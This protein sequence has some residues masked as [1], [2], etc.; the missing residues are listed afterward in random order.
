MKEHSLTW[1]SFIILFLAMFALSVAWDMWNRVLGNLQL[2]AE[3]AYY[4]QRLEAAT[5]ENRKLQ[6]L[7]A[8]VQTDTWVEKFAR[9]RLHY[10]RPDEVVVLPRSGDNTAPATIPTP[11][12]TPVPT[13]PVPTSPPEQPW[14]EQWLDWLFGPMQ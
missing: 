8:I 5:A 2:M 10:A 14:W 1:T 3:E 6:E 12:P 7:K 4:S 11:A 13:N 9:T